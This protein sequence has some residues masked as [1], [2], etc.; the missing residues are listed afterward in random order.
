[1]FFVTAQVPIIHT[2]DLFGPVK[3]KMEEKHPVE[4]LLCGKQEVSIFRFED[5]TDT[6]YQKVWSWHAEDA[7]NFPDSLAD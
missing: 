2:S 6:V 1:M 4:L 3:I 5:K 7:V